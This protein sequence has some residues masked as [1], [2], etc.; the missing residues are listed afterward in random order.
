[1]RNLTLV[2]AV[3]AVSSIAVSSADAQCWRRCKARTV[4]ICKP[5]FQTCLPCNLGFAPG[6][7]QQTPAHSPCEEHVI[8]QNQCGCS[9]SGISSGTFA[10]ELPS[11][12]G[13]W[14]CV[15]RGNDGV[16]GTGRHRLYDFAHSNALANCRQHSTQPTTCSV[17]KCTPPKQ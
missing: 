9:A 17:K 15:A 2:V 6:C 14:V 11:A 10:G 1:M 16:G 12:A 7:V 3:I 5:C 8:V 13:Q 4:P